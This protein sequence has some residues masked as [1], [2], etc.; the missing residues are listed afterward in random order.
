MIK[1]SK[2][3]YICAVNQTIRHTVLLLLTLSILLGSFGVALSEDG[4][5]TAAVLQGAVAVQSR[6]GEIPVPGNT[7]AA[8]LQPGQGLAV[9]ADGRRVETVETPT[10][11]PRLRAFIEWAQDTLMQ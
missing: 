1:W 6:T 5:T 11:S 2:F 4:K 7:P 3:P 9:Q 10:P 8:L